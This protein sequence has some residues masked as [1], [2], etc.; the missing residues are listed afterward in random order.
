MHKSLLWA[1]SA[2]ALALTLSGCS[3]DLNWRQTGFEGTTFKADLPC[4][5][6]RTT[7]QVPL[8]GLPVDLQVSGCESGTAMVAVMTAALPSG[9]DANALLQG[10]Q[11]ATLANLQAQDAQ[12]QAWARPGMLPLPAAQRLSA[13]GRR[14]DGQPV[15]VQAVWGALVEGDH[16][17]LVHAAVYD[18]QVAAELA[19]TLFESLK[20]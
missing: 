20:P 12:R 19:D 10:W 8:G 16:V 7:R 1:L 15:A 3:P 4:K 9:S 6:D 14:A 2:L 13:Q 17:R 5:P 11:Q 18:R